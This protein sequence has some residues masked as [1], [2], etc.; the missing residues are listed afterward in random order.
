MTGGVLGNYQFDI[1]RHAVSTHAV[2]AQAF[3]RGDEKW[4][5]VR[6]AAEQDQL[7]RQAVGRLRLIGVETGGLDDEWP[8]EIL[9]QP[10]LRGIWRRRRREELAVGAAFIQGTRRAFVVKEL[11]GAHQAAE[12]DGHGASQDIGDDMARN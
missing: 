9:L 3:N 6:R 12:G 4:Q 2:P 10:K 1:E 5:P 8:G 11:L 7:K